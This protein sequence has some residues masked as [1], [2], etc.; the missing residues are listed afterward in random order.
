MPRQLRS[1]DTD[2]TRIGR[3]L[4]A[5]PALGHGQR[6]MGY[7]CGMC[8]CV[9]ALFAGFA[10]RSSRFMACGAQAS[11][12]EVAGIMTVNNS[13]DVTDS[14]NPC[15]DV[16]APLGG[17]DLASKLQQSAKVKFCDYWW[18]LQLLARRPRGES[19]NESCAA[20]PPGV[21]TL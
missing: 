16:D 8:G 21:D 1:S 11:L 20:A 10:V 3:N 14:A 5:T 19:P 7:Q 18:E 13:D 6:C 15:G 4:L 17:H 12:H 9:G 2:G